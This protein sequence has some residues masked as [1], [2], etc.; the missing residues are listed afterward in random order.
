MGYDMYTVKTERYFRANI[1]GMGMLR[2]AM[3][4]AGVDFSAVSLRTTQ[5]D[6]HENGT[7]ESYSTVGNLMTCFS[8]NDGWLVRPEECEEIAERLEQST[9]K[10]FK[11]LDLNAPLGTARYLSTTPSKEDLKFLE[12]FKEYCTESAKEGGFYVW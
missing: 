6:P 2:Q 7:E 5:G 12:G 9:L 4:Q 10:L 11:E 1:W 3:E 8:S